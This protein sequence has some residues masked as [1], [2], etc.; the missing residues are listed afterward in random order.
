MLILNVMWKE[1][2]VVIKITKF[3]YTK[4]DQDHIAV[5]VVTLYVLMINLDQLFIMKVK[6]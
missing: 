5:L 3:L 1:L 2:R 6:M 4:K